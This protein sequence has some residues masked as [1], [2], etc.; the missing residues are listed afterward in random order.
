MEF[1]KV[2]TGELRKFP[3]L[4]VALIAVSVMLPVIEIFIPLNLAKILNILVLQGKNPGQTGLV[5][6]IGIFVGL[7]LLKAALTSLQLRLGFS[8]DANISEGIRSRCLHVLLTPSPVALRPGLSSMTMHLNSLS[9]FWG[10][11][12]WETLTSLLFMSGACIALLMTDQRLALAAF[13]PVPI[14]LMIVFYLGPRFRRTMQSYFSGVDAIGQELTE[15]AENQDFIKVSGIKILMAQIFESHNRKLTLAAK[16]FGY[17]AALYAPI[18]DFVAAS[19]T[20]L[21]VVSFAVWGDTTGQETFLMFFVYLSY[22][23]RP[24]Y[25]ASSISESW[26]KTFFAYESFAAVEKKLVIPDPAA[27]E[28]V[29][30]KNEDDNSLLPRNVAFTFQGVSF[31]YPGSSEVISDLNAVIPA[32]QITAIVGGNGLGKS[33]LIKLMTGILSPQ[34]GAIFSGEALK[35][36]AYLPQ[37]VFLHSGSIL[38]NLLL[39]HPSYRPYMQDDERRHLVDGIY[40]LG[41]E[42]GVR[43]RLSQVDL[44]DSSFG[45]G[46]KQLSGGQRQLV[47]LWRFAIQA[48]FAN[49]LVMDEPDSYLD[50]D[51]LNL[52]L[53][54]VLDKYRCKTV[55]VVSHNANVIK[56]CDSVLRL[57]K[58]KLT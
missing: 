17:W 21:L 24:L 57:E 46:K 39:I 26:Q 19:A 22:F 40:A 2:I 44:E 23:Y 36:F 11:M 12:F 37:T 30:S 6:L 16:A 27:S 14:V 48:E 15:I 42:I 47:G 54:K 43:Q 45:V 8:L 5:F 20:A 49:T 33:T 38:D 7:N 1:I 9:K 51:G 34:R 41:T 4:A 52:V 56:M 18:F 28:N 13:V 29:V 50:I 10:T 32:N 31:A 53:P 35:S 3:R 25:G 55:V 58:G